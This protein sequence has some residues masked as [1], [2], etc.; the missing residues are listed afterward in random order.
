[1]SDSSL[2]QLAQT[3]VDILTIEL[4]L[5]KAKQVVQKMDLG[6]GKVEFKGS[7]TASGFRNEVQDSE[8]EDSESED[9]DNSMPEGMFLSQNKW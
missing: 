1:M 2:R 5:A 9:S 3:N 4:S 8:S 6:K 7:V